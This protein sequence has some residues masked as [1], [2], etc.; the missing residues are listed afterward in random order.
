MQPALDKPLRTELARGKQ[1]ALSFKLDDP[2]KCVRAI[3]AGGAGVVD[4]ELSLVDDKGQVYGRDAL[5][6]PF[7]LVEEGGPV[8]LP[9]PGRYRVVVRMRRGAGHVAVQIYRA[10]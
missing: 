9:A 3:A 1:A 8:C 6:A 5:E 10:K 7:A 2:S 4:L